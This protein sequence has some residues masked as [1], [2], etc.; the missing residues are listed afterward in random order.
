MSLMNQDKT[1]CELLMERFKSQ[2]DAVRDEL[3]HA[4]AYDA[5]KHI[6]I[7][8]KLQNHL[9][10]YLMVEWFG[11]QLGNHLWEKFAVH[12]KRNILSWLSKLTSEY[13]FFVI[14]KAIERFK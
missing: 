1:P 3:K 4:G 11:E 2:P 6:L 8:E 12:H 14:L 13:R 9:S 7:M 10:G 5:S